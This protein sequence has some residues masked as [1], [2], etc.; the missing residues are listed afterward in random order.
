MPQTKNLNYKTEN[1]HTWNHKK[2]T[3]IAR[4]KTPTHAKSQDKRMNNLSFETSTK[5]KAIVVKA[6]VAH[7]VHKQFHKKM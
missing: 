6:I 3:L 1:T 5:F 7:N 2:P 4:P